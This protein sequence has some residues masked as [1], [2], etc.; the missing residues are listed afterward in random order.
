MSKVIAFDVTSSFGFFRKNF[1]STNALTH[2]MI[3]RSAVEGLVGAIIG[4]SRKDYPDELELS[5][6]AIEILSPIRKLNIKYM[7]TDPKWWS[8]IS[9]Y[10]Q[11]TDESTLTFKH[12]AI[13]ASAE[14]LVNPSYRIY[15]DA[16]KNINY[17]L[18]DNLKNKQSYYTP[19]MGT[20]SMICSTKH[21]SEF[22]YQNIRPSKTYIPVSSIIPFSKTIP[23]IELKKG[24]K[25][26]IEE[27]LPLHID[28]KRSPQGTYSAVYN[29]EAEPINITN[30]EDLAAIQIGESLY[31]YVKFL[32]TQ[33]PYT[34]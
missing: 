3:P 27:D 32:P 10:L 29:P 12:F 30:Y 4:L 16:N 20:S 23:Q 34:S 28:N 31:T 18:S 15:I 7:H 5:K 26:A 11:Q 24:S 6:I 21:V 19:Y 2:A 1:T 8:T 17:C 22:D 9:H 25:F 13:P 14:F 33:I